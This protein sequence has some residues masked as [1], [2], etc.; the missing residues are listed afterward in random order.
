MRGG[1]G[2][3][4]VTSPLN[5]KKM[6]DFLKEKKNNEY[7][8]DSSALRFQLYLELS[9]KRAPYCLYCGEKI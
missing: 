8:E 2:H 9:S 5:V 4:K 1:G 6:H 3:Q 7:M